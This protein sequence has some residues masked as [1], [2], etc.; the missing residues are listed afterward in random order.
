MGKCSR[1]R[2]ERTKSASPSM[3][4]FIGFRASKVWKFSMGG[5]AVV[6]EA[7]EAR[8]ASHRD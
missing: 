7:V 8:R 6:C 1:T 5:A 4:R 2:V 3:P